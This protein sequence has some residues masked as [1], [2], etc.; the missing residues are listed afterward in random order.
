M[1]QEEILLYRVEHLQHIDCDGE[2]RLSKKE[3]HQR[4]LQNVD[5]FRFQEKSMRI[6]CSQLLQ[7]T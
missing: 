4:F 7:Y 5:T 2:I 3:Y 1:A 6:V